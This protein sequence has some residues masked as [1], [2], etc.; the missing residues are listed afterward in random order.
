MTPTPLTLQQE[1]WAERE[2]GFYD[3]L[4]ESHKQMAADYADL[5]DYERAAR[6]A[7]IA[8]TYARVADQLRRPKL[9]RLEMEEHESRAS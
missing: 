7:I 1:A 2:A 6:V 4:V 8:E 9:I 3:R 5:H